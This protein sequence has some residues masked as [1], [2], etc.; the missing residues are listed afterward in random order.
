[1][2]SVCDFGVCRPAVLATRKYSDARLINVSLCLFLVTRN[3]ASFSYH[4]LLNAHEV[5]PIDTIT[6]PMDDNNKAFEYFLRL[7]ATPSSLQSPVPDKPKI[8]L[9][10]NIFYSFLKQHDEHLAITRQLILAVLNNASTHGQ[11]PLDIVVAN[12]MVSKAVMLLHAQKMLLSTVE[13]FQV[14]ETDVGNLAYL[15]ADLSFSMLM[16][17]RT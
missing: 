1:M 14:P 17:P 5:T 9:D 8:V 15:L 16:P 6:S 4:S 7:S 3:A 13:N 11:K 10:S 2:M 12:Q